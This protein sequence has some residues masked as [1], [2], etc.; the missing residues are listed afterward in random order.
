[1][2][3]AKRIQLEIQM[4]EII[5]VVHEGDRVKSPQGWGTVTAVTGE[6]VSQIA[7]TDFG[8]GESHPVNPEDLWFVESSTSKPKLPSFAQARRLADQLSPD[9]RARLMAHLG[10]G[11]NLA[12]VSDRVKRRVT[13]GSLRR[14]AGLAASLLSNGARVEFLA[15]TLGD[16]P[17]E[18]V[19]SVLA[20]SVSRSLADAEKILRLMEGLRDALREE[21]KR[22]EEEGMS[23]VDRAL[24]TSGGG[25][26]FEM[27]TINGHGP[28][29]Y[30][31]FNDT[32]DCGGRVCRSV[33]ADQR[34][35]K[36]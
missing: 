14:T 11:L 13:V 23:S 3:K 12:D 33:Y 19:R 16:L 26:W 24:K 29:R 2:P 7:M 32:G 25:G 4:P 5:P 6:G 15:E 9:D 1:M 28:Y 34:R 18:D 35:K 17:V 27:K 36:N 8:S 21:D 20:R 31:R 10:D 30:L 22:K